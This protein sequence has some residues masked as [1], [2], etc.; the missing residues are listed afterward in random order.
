MSHGNHVLYK[1]LSH[2]NI[3]GFTS[4][5]STIDLLFTSERHVRLFEKSLLKI[6]FAN[7]L[8]EILLNGWQIRLISSSDVQAMYCRCAISMNAD[9]SL[10]S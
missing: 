6:L 9:P 8:C 4:E 5:K 1:F 3:K 2:N 10:S 7:L